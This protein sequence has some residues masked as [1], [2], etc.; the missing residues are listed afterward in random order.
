[1]PL[2]PLLGVEHSLCGRP[3]RPRLDAHGEAQALAI[4]QLGGH[5]DGL[6]RVLAA[7]G[8]APDATAAY[9]DPAVRDLM[10]DP[11][12]LADMDA[13]VERLA[14][15]VAAGTRIA[16]FGDYDVDGAASAALLA[17][18]LTAC[19]TPHVIHIPDRLFEGYGPNVEAVRALAAGGAGL[20]VASIAAPPATPRSPRPPPSGLAPIILDHHQA[21]E[22]LPPALVVN[23][24]GSTTSPASASSAPPAWSSWRWWPCSACCAAADSSTRLE[25]SPTCCA[26]STSWRWRPSPTWRR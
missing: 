21:P 7:R 24:T 20:L 23:P 9:L 17:D 13:A 18:Y 12:S 11:S 8:I 25:R 1:M 26:R 14:D 4:A 2:R 19:G 10:P 16:I 6:S 22:L 15:A 3:W 5:G